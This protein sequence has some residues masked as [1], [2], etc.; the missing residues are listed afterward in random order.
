MASGAERLRAE[1]ERLTDDEE[2]GDAAKRAASET[3]KT[4]RKPARWCAML[5]ATPAREF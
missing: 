1:A 2:V 5:L 4:S 3:V